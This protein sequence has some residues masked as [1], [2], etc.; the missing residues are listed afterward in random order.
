MSKNYAMVNGV[1]IEL[2]DNVDELTFTRKPV[3]EEKEGPFKRCEFEDYYFFIMSDGVV[4]FT[5]EE[6]RDLDDDRFAIA[7]YCTDKDM[8]KQQALRET[9]NRLLWRYSA[10][11]G[12]DN[13]WDRIEIHWFITKDF[14]NDKFRPIST[15]SL[16]DFGAVHFC[17]ET[18]AQSAIRDVVV[19]FMEEHPDFIW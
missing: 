11:H 5:T 10:Q 13:E 9:L 3:E 6:G 19:P 16:K 7:N 14:T 4:F 8:M 18:T 15:T 17:D 1:K 2:P 12:G